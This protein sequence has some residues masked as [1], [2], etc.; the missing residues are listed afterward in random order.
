MP[1]ELEYTTFLT[2]ALPELKDKFFC[3]GQLF[4][5]DNDDGEIEHV[6]EQA[7]EQKLYGNEM[8]KSQ[9]FV[10]AI[11][12]YKVGIELCDQYYLCGV[13]NDLK[14]NMAQML[15]NTRQ[16]K[17]AIEILKP[18]V[19]DQRFNPKVYYRLV[20]AYRGQGNNSLAEKYDKIYKG[21]MESER[22]EK[23]EKKAEE[24]YRKDGPTP[25]LPQQPQKKK[26]L[27]LAQMY[28]KSNKINE[29]SPPV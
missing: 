10:G 9:D 6:V 14:G 24:K 16:F 1:D 4:Y 23:T 28:N 3:R 8:A 21:L 22:E 29:D 11:E 17:E 19:K 20:Q 18:L 13:Q 5:R 2:K 12:E 25:K 27:D 15:I 7:L 26:G